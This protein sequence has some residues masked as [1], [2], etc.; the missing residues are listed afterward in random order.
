VYRRIVISLHRARAARDEATVRHLTEQLIE[1]EL[2]L[3]GDGRGIAAL[4]R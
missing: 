2:S 3:G 4:I 1:L